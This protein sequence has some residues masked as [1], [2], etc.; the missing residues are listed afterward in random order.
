MELTE[1]QKKQVAAWL[2]EGLKLADVQKRMETDMGLRPT[3]MEVKLLVGDLRLMPKD[4]DPAPVVESSG[5]SGRS[6]EGAPNPPGGALDSSGTPGPAGGQVSVSLDQVVQAGA[7]A[8]GAVTFSDGKRATW[9]LD[10]MGRLG[11]SPQ[12]Q[13]YRPSESDMQQFRSALENELSKSGY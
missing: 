9:F 3:Y 13:G 12:E 2:A 6:G 5:L 7:L 1:E 10:Q 8:S 4:D 11:L